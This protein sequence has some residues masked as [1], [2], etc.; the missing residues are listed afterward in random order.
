MRLLGGLVVQPALA[1]GVAFV[2]FP[3]LLLDRSG[4]TLAG[5][6]PA[7]PID[8]AVSVALGAGIVAF[9]VTLVGVLP[10]ALWIVRRRRLTFMAALLF[11]LGFGNLPVV[12]GTVLIGSY[13]PSSLLRG[14]AFASLIGL[15]G[16]AAFWVISIRGRDFSRDPAA[17]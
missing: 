3:L 7:D 16:A 5:G 9:F 1:G 13:G 2:S 15:T 14:V 8:A 12:L 17:G 10:V 4:R 11:G 6:F